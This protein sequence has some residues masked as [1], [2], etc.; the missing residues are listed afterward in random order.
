MFILVIAVTFHII[1]FTVSGKPIEWIAVGSFTGIVM[2][3]K[4]IQKGIEVRADRNKIS[5]PA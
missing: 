4:V 1:W 3:G 5:E 2:A